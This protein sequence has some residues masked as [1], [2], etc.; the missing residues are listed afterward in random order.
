MGFIWMIIVGLVA[1]LL[2]RA[3]KPGIFNRAWPLVVINDT[4]VA[5]DLLWQHSYVSWQAKIYQFSR[6]YGFLRAAHDAVSQHMAYLLIFIKI[7][8]IS[9]L[10]TIDRRGLLN[11]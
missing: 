7:T 6:A 10:V 2:A 8:E 3:I 9:K 4:D 11:S 5:I 1:G